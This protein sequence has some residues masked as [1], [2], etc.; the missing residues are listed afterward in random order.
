MALAQGAYQPKN[1]DNDHDET[2]DA[3]KARHPVAAVC[4]VSATAA[5]QQDKYNN[6]EDQRH[7]S[8]V[9]STPLSA[10]AAVCQTAPLGHR[11]AAADAPDEKSPQE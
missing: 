3:A 4:V 5:E 11:S 2:E 10:P 8:P 9:W 1:H 7:G 6:D